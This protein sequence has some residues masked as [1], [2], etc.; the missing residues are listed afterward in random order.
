MT[1][2][3]KPVLGSKEVVI[4]A[5]ALALGQIEQSY[6]VAG[7]SPEAI[8]AVGIFLMAL[9]RVFVTKAPVNWKKLF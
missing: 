3:E 7:V 6:G 8:Y 4:G 9:L 5:I 2:D 1:M